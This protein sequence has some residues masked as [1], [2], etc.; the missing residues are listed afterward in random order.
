M[1]IKLG[2]SPTDYKAHEKVFFDM[3]HEDPTR[4]VGLFRNDTTGE[5]I[6][7]RGKQGVVSVETDKSK[8]AG[9]RSGARCLARRSSAGRR[10]SSSPTRRSDTGS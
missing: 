4:E 6:I 9:S 1:V 3:L 2:G 5:V 10:T 7:V 8:P